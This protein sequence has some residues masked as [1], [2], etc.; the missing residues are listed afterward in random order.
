MPVSDPSAEDPALGHV[1][2]D[3]TAGCSEAVEQAVGETVGDGADRTVAVPMPPPP[4]GR[5][6]GSVLMAAMVGLSEALGFDK[7]QTVIEVSA[8]SGE[9]LDLD[10][11]DLPPLD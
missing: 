11:G 1:H 3:V 10:F 6:N 2:E 5:A 7:P 4:G 8:A 9:G